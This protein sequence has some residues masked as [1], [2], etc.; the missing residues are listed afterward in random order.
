MIHQLYNFPRTK[1]FA[2]ACSGG[3][4][5]M[6]IASFYQKGGKNFTLAYF[7]HGT[8]QA[9]EMRLVVEEFAE[10]HGIPIDIGFLTKEKDPKQSPEEFFRNERYGWLCSLGQDIITCHHLGDSVEN[11]IFSSLHG[12]PKLI[13]SCSMLSFNGVN[14]TVYRP[15]LTNTKQSLQDW[16]IRNKVKWCEDLS[17][18]DIKYPRNFIRHQL[19]EQCLKVNPGL[20]NT[21][22]RKIIHTYQT[23]QEKGTI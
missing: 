5:S 13:A 15:F 14:A 18:Q 11:W 9:D 3:V 10:K 20:I 2:L 1:P 4:D 16:C 6:A 8:P 17:N 23:Y 22:R 21:I 19:L 7:H 12:N